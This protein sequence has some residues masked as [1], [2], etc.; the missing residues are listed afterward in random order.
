MEVILL[1]KIP[2]LGQLG[3]KVKVRPGYGRN[4]LIP[5]G[6]AA[7][8]TPANLRKFE[9]RRADLERQAIGD[10]ARAEERREQLTDLVVTLSVKAG[11]EGRLFGSVAPADIAGAVSAAGIELNKREVRL[12]EGPIRQVGEYPVEVHLHPEVDTTI[13]VNVI[14]A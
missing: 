2:N 14:P 9:E 4:Y 10:L 6:K 3:E 5:Q 11:N 1:E 12:P 8:A 13:H 7:E